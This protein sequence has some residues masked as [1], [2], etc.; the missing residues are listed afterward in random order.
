MRRRRHLE[1]KSSPRRP[2][3]F[4]C[5]QAPPPP[6]RTPC[7]PW[8][9]CAAPWATPRLALAASR[10]PAAAATLRPSRVRTP[11]WWCRSCSRRC[12]RTRAWPR[13][14]WRWTRSTWNCPAPP[15][16]R[17]PAPSWTT[18]STSSTAETRRSGERWAAAACCCRLNRSSTCR[19]APP[20][21]PW[22]RSTASSD[23][24]TPPWATCPTHKLPWLS[25][26]RL[27]LFFTAVPSE[28]SNDGPKSRWKGRHLLDHMDHSYLNYEPVLL[29]SFNSHSILSKLEPSKQRH[30]TLEVLKSQRA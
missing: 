12:P 11:A 22:R 26:G 19:A 16:L 18:G 17:R 10:V 20:S 8:S 2:S 3:T 1:L 15:A 23:R 9:G 28:F 13:R 27:V 21:R 25:R 5:R 30:A 29:L 7:W 6:R 4:T 14:A 24:Q